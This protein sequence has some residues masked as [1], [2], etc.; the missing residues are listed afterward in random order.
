[1]SFK[2]IRDR[3]ITKFYTRFPALLRI[4]AR[5]HQFVSN[6]DTPWTPLQKELRYAKIALVTTAGVHL[7]SDPPYNMQDKEGDPTFRQIPSSIR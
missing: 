7:R 1:M 2:T 6:A 4:W 3:I 5:M